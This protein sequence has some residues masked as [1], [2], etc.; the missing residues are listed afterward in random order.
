MLRLKASYPTTSYAGMEWAGVLQGKYPTTI[1]PEGTLS[2]SLV[3]LNDIE[4]TINNIQ[5]LTKSLQAESTKLMV[6][7]GGSSSEAK[8][9]SCVAD[10]G[11]SAASFKELRET[12]ISSVCEKLLLPKFQPLVEVF[13]SFSHVLS[14]KDYSNYEVNDPFVQGFILG[15]DVIFNEVKVTLMPEVFNL[16]LSNLTNEIA[17]KIEDQIFKCRFNELGGVQF[18]NNLR[19]LVGYFSSLTQWAIQDKFA[20]LSQMGT[21][22]NLGLPHD[23]T[24]QNFK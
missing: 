7:I 19:I 13:G 4:V 16:L 22:L 10:L 20:R 11:S 18:D 24:L 6:K 14:E 21:I 2:T 5:K 8:L 15:A 23:R 3:V 1:E 17:Y 9:D 12:A